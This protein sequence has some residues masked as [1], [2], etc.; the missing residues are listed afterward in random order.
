MVRFHTTSPP[1]H[2]IKRDL[3]QI[4]R[5][6]YNGGMPRWVTWVL[7]VAVLGC[8]EPAPLTAQAG[9][10]PTDTTP[11]LGQAWTR[12]LASPAAFDLRWTQHGAFLAWSEP[13][14]SRQSVRG[15][16]L[17]ADGRPGKVTTL[18]DTDAEVVEVA[19]GYAPSLDQL[20]VAWVQRRPGEQAQLRGT[21]ADG[22][23]TRF[24]PAATVGPTHVAHVGERG[25]LAI[26]PGRGHLHVYAR[27]EDQPC[28]DGK[29][30]RCASFGAHPLPPDPAA[31]NRPWLTVPRPCDRP[32][33]GYL[34]R[35]PHRY[36]GICHLREDDSRQE[37]VW[38]SI[39]PEPMYA[40]A[41]EL[42]AGCEPRGAA[43]LDDAIWVTAACGSIRTGVRIRGI[44]VDPP[45]SL[46]DAELTCNA[47]GHPV[48]TLEREHPLVAPADHLGPLLPGEVGGTDAAAVWTGEVLLVARH[49]AREVEVARYRCVEGLFVR[50][51]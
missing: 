26:A 11:K 48:L 5:L 22:E 43:V 24:A 39:Q 28:E 42:M 23:P 33:T 8:E 31:G 4:H 46:D 27:G 3:E 49:V 17:D 2:W 7:A 38:Y 32:V 13:H 15:V 25:H 16:R 30:S 44:D 47:G 20:G 36:Y 6:H 21:A 40:Q 29:P 51:G 37:T 41:H 50:E 1:A 10:A 12:P 35:P 45:R 14:G 19:L 9:L 18:D 34:Y